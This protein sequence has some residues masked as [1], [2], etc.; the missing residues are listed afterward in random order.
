MIFF[1]FSLEGF[2]I[3]DDIQ[4]VE[5]ILEKGYRSGSQAKTT[6]N[7]SLLVKSCKVFSLFFLSCTLVFR[8]TFVG[9]RLFFQVLCNVESFGRVY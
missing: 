7:R 3:L 1:T 5:L 6:M 8:W 2:G 4:S 9:F